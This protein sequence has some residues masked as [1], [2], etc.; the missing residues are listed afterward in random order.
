MSMLYNG[1]KNFQLDICI[2]WPESVVGVE[3]DICMVCPK[4]QS[5]TSNFLWLR[6][7]WCCLIN[8]NS[9]V[10][11]NFEHAMSLDVFF[12]GF[13]ESILGDTPL[14]QTLNKV[15]QEEF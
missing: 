1:R 11:Y 15:F 13:S 9:K 3:V 2:S 6:A 4:Q 14:N 5:Q 10:K 8:F 7:E 12:S